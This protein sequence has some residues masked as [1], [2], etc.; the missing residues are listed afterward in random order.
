MKYFSAMHKLHLL[1]VIEY[2]F[3]LARILH[4]RSWLR[5]FSFSV[6]MCLL[7]CVAF[8]LLLSLNE[9]KWLRYLVL[10]WFS[11]IGLD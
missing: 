1:L 8:F 5:L 9:A 10:N 11:V 3:A 2:E 6:H 4:F 7:R